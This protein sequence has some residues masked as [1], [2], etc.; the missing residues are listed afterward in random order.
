MFGIN[1]DDLAKVRLRRT[2][3]AHLKSAIAEAKKV[4]EMAPASMFKVYYGF[5]LIKWLYMAPQIS[6][7]VQEKVEE[8]DDESSSWTG[9]ED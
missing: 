1:P 3:N 8:E 6:N 4:S 9:S 7:I 2:S 5:D